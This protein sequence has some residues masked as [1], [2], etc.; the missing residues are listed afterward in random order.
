MRLPLTPH[1][2]FPTDA[3]AALTVE[4][5]RPGPLTLNLR[6]RLTGDIA[7]LAIPAPAA[8]ERTDELW[9]HT[10][11]E[12]FVQPE[13]GE[14][15]AELNFAPS[16]QW[17]AYAFTGYREGMA[18]ASIAA[19]RIQITRTTDVLELGVQLNL[20]GLNLP[21][22]PCQLALAVVVE[23]TGGAKSYWALAHPPGRPDFHHRSGFACALPQG[24]L[25]R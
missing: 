14:G 24:D 9:R 2:D 13:G 17:A 1:P 25:T 19:P 20:A 16:T 22:T 23:E 5:A 12:A 3:V 15:Y 21:D 6:Y 8:P 4:L 11:F 7:R 18:P 10:C